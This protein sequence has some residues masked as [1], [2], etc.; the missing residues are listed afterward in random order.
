MK[1]E[2]EKDIP[3]FRGKNWRERA[4]LRREAIRNDNSIRWLSFLCSILCFC[5]SPIL[6]W[7]GVH[8]SLLL[9]MGVYL[10][11]AALFT[12]LFYCA[13]ITPRVRRALESHK[14]STA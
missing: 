9:L 4:A 1:L 11:L 6:I 3:A 7:I 10:I 13:F 14:T 8:S 12:W 2:R 5:F